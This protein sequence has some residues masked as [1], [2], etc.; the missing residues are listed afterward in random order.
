[1]TRRLTRAAFGLAT[2]LA[3]AAAGAQDA[4][5]WTYGYGPV[6]QLTEGTL[7]GGVNDLS[8]VYYNPGALA[9]V[10]EPRFV[11]GLTS[12]ELAKIDAPDAA[13]NHLDFDSTVF[14][15]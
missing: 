1:M 12:I 6:G 3:S 15:V 4:H 14:D 8:A 13:G 11:F 10:K 7:V 2:L 9:L 5:Y